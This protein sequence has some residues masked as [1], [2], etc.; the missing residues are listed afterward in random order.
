MTDGVIR[1]SGRGFGA[2]VS[3]ETF[4][5]YRLRVEYRFL[6]GE[7]F[8]WKKGWAPDSGILF[9]STGRDRCETK[10]ASN[11]NPIGEWN[12]AELVCRGDEVTAIFN[13]KVVN[14]GFGAKPTSGRIQLQMEGCPIEFRRVTLDPLLPK[15]E[16][17]AGDFREG[18]VRGWKSV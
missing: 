1:M 5:N 6:G 16:T 2:L 12:V 9:H 13:G 7:Q 4:S 18:D 8:G 15:F 3:E 17:A 10:I 14:R 11:E